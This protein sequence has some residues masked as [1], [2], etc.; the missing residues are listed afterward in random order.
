MPEDKPTVIHTDRRRERDR[1]DDGR[2]RKEGSSQR[3]GLPSV[4]SVRPATD[5]QEALKMMTLAEKLIECSLDFLEPQMTRQ[6]FHLMKSTTLS[7][8]S[9]LTNS[10]RKSSSVQSSPGEQS[11]PSH[12]SDNQRKRSRESWTPS[13]PP[14][15]HLVPPPVKRE[16]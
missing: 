15:S 13:P 11:R 1:D 6:E 5:Q 3:M 7:V 4:S 12:H 16:R 8:L 9:K 2:R 10:R 14:R